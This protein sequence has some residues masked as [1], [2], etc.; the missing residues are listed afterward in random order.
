MQC[1]KG[2][3][4][5]E[6]LSSLKKRCHELT[7]AGVTVT[8][9]KYKHTIIYGL[10]GPLS[11]YASQTMGSLC[12]TCKLTHKSFNMTDIINTLCEEADHLTT[13]KDSA[14]GQ[15]KGKGK[16]WSLP[17]ASD[18]ALAATSP[19]EGSNSRCCKGKCHHCQKEGHWVC[20]CHTRKRE[21]AMAAADQNAQAVQLNPGTTSKPKNKPVG[22]ANHIY[23]DDSDDNSF[24]M[25]EEDIAH[26]YP[27]YVEP[28]PL[29]GELEDND[30]NKWKA[31]CTKT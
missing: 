19:Y 11:T 25:A 28:D 13:M 20:D 8:K 15:G 31:F 9:P 18:D 6:F 29:M 17:P 2:G 14:Q 3:D 5:Q 1:L 27:D 30:I 24:Y 10:P 23:L 4:V 26:T 12:L 22:S 16:N 7:A 21:E